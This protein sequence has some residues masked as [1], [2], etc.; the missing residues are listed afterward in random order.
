M[1][2]HVSIKTHDLSHLSYILCS[3][4]FPTFVLYLACLSPS[5][6]CSLVLA[7][8]TTH[9]FHISSFSFVSYPYLLLSSRRRRRHPN[10][11]RLHFSPSSTSALY[12]ALSPIRRPSHQLNP[13][14]Q[15]PPAFRYLLEPHVGGYDTTNLHHPLSATHS[16]V[17]FFF[18]TLFS[19][20]ICLVVPLVYHM[21]Q[22]KITHSDSFLLTFF[23]FLSN[24]DRR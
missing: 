5:I 19:I 15:L 22:P 10:S 13:V 20:L 16:R 24:G 2:D 21:C 23:G 6:F 3:T 17:F 11:F 1:N 8:A 18:N 9:L 12:W 7:L 4:F 14:F